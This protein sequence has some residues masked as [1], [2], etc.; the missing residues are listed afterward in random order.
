MR[1]SSGNAAPDAPRPVD[2]QGLLEIARRVA[3]ELHPRSSGHRRVT[4]DSSLDRDLGLDSLGRAELITRLEKAYGVGLPE[5]LLAAAETPRDLLRAVK[6][7]GARVA[8][9][10]DAESVAT[11]LA[12]TEGS[13]QGAR[14]LTEALEWHLERH[15]ERRHIAFLTGDG[16]VREMTYGQLFESARAVASGLQRLGLEHGRTVGLILPTGLEYFHAFFGVLLAGGVPVPLYPPARPSQLEDHLRRQARILS[17]ALVEVLIAFPEVIPLARLLRAQVPTLRR[18]VTVAELAA[19]PPPARL[20]VVHDHDVA[21]LQFTS[22]STADPKGVI[23]THANLLANLRSIGR[24]ATLSSEDVVVS[25]LPLYH[26][27]GLIGAWMGSLYFAM[28]LA[29]MSPL[30]FLSRPERWLW[31][32]HRHR[33]T[34]SAAPNFAY[35]LCLKK[36][37]D[38][39]IEGLDLSSWRASLNGAEPVSAETIRRFTERFTAYGYRSRT[40][41]PV[42]GLAE[43]SLALAFPPPEDE[44]VVDIVDRET[45]S[46]EGRAQAAAADDPK[47]LRFVSCGFALPDHEIRIVDETGV[48]LG[49]RREGRLEFRGPS[50]TSGYFRN[51]EAT[52]RLFSGEWLDSGDRAYVAEGQVFITGRAKDMIIRAGRNIYPQEL[53]EAIGTVAGVRKGCVAVFGSADPAT[54]T[55]RLIVLAETR[56]AGEE[57]HEKIRSDIQD[58]AIALVGAPADDVV[59]APPHS[60]PKTSSG[61]IR[62]AAGRELYEGGGVR[63]RGPVWWQ[64]A[65]LALAGARPQITRSARAARE[66]LYAGRFWAVV[67]LAAVPVAAALVAVPR[68]TRRRRLARRVARQVAR[69]NAI[70]IRV[71][72]LEHLKGEGP[73]IVASNHASYLDG[74]ALTATLPAQGAF[75]AK[76]ELTGSF[77]ARLLLE[78]LGTLFVERFDPNQGLEDIQRAVETIAR[79]ESLLFF[80]EGTFDRAPGL[81]P[82]RL[83]AFYVAAQA[84]VPVVPVAIRG[85]RSLLRGDEGFPR[86]GALTVRVCPPIHPDGTDFAAAARL[87]DAVRAEILKHCGEPDLVRGD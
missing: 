40:M 2:A 76:K 23:L 3:D 80:P 64:L 66:V 60:V 81:R 62:R 58:L 20:P 25:W 24:A 82:F 86:R 87:R 78:R 49:E 1:A 53:E 28:P 41:M 69:L 17:T 33:G 36:V 42:Y 39:A 4:L 71:D 43:C 31:A 37:D 46:R 50:T 38:E 54:G 59:L 15:P 85:T 65:R 45:L 5:G 9:G 13:P 47:A 61:K 18:V 68:L 73:R 27:M 67:G 12:A 30:A 22:G 74:F 44:P 14:T 10:A 48:E 83:G 75:L 70:P 11:P 19:A 32:I 57:T 29:L 77:L 55:E 35:E 56:E 52:K 34:I 51:P 8:A 79:G 63:R 21:F 26:D 72:G 7:G 84:G 16:S 6:S